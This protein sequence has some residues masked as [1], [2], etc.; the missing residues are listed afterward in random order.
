MAAG[1]LSLFLSFPHS[2]FSIFLSLSLF[3][4]IANNPGKFYDIQ[5]LPRI[6]LKWY[7]HLTEMLK[8]HKDNPQQPFKLLTIIQLS[9]TLA[10]VPSF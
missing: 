3:P 8:G 2:V 1:P 7:F 5:S 4:E 6:F 9:D 10:N